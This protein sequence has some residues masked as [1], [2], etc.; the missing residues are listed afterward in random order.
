[1]I[2]EKNSFYYPHTYPELEE[3]V[4]VFVVVDELVVDVWEDGAVV[5]ECKGTIAINTPPIIITITDNIIT[6]NSTAFGIFMLNHSFL[7]IKNFF[8]N[9]IV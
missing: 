4:E 6:A 2:L 5:W 9:L 1:M 3:L 8:P 7:Y